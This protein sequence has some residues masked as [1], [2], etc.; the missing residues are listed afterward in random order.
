[1]SFED[2]RVGTQGAWDRFYSWQRVWA[3]AHVVESVRARLA[4]V[5]V[6]K[7]YRQMYANTGL[8]TDSAREQRSTRWARW[9]GRACTRFFLGKPLPDLAVP[10][11]QLAAAD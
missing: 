2:L 1:M 10:G 3:R 9:I 4:F 5:L 7:L 11:E 8:A 6:S